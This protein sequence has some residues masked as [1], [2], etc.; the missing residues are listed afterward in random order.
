MRAYDFLFTF[1]RNCASLLSVI[2]TYPTC[3]WF[4]V[5]GKYNIVV[6]IHE[7]LWH[8]KTS[9]PGILCSAVWM[10]LHLAILVEL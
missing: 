5:G 1:H 9:I 2:L 3:I 8:Q 7:D 10:I 6:Q 4:L